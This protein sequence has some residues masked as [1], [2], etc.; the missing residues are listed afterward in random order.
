MAND[1]FFTFKIIKSISFC[2]WTVSN[3]YAFFTFIIKFSSFFLEGYENNKYFQKFW[4]ALQMAWF[5]SMFQLEFCSSIPL[6]DIYWECTRLSE[7]FYWQGFFI[8]NQCC[9]FHSSPVFSFS[10]FILLWTVSSSK[11]LP[12]S[13][14]FA[15]FFKLFWVCLPIIM[16]NLDTAA[17]LLFYKRFKSLEN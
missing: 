1:Y 15:K 16:N 13:F 8:E 14:I 7:K 11:L 2:H 10:N 4:S 17:T 6:L 5:H 12:N 9:H 3:E